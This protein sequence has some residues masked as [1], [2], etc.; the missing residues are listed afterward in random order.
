MNLKRRRPR[1]TSNDKFLRAV[2]L[3][4][5]SF[6][7]RTTRLVLTCLFAVVLPLQGM[8]VGI[9]AALGPAHFHKPAEEMLVLEDV[10]HWKPSR[11]HQPNFLAFLGHSHGPA[12]QRHYHAFDDVSVVNLELDST[13]HGTSV[14]EGVSASGLL[15]SLCAVH[16]GR[17]IWTPLQG[18]N[19]LAPMRP[20]WTAISVVVEPLDR[21]P[22]AA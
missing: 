9:F 12:S 4:L 8:A 22:R 18:L 10:R 1:N 7:R 13:S 15:A 5:S 21:P 3:T 17:M 6:S 11:L 19:A 2:A 20:F 14:D 16:P